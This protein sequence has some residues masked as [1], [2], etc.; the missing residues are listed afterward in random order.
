[1]ACVQLHSL[2][3]YHHRVFEQ[4]G[5]DELAWLTDFQPEN[6]FDGVGWEDSPACQDL[7][8]D[9]ECVGQYPSTGDSECL[10]EPEWCE[11][12]GDCLDCGQRAVTLF[13][14]R[15]PAALLHGAE[16]GPDTQERNHRVRERDQLE[17]HS[18]VKFMKHLTLTF[19]RQ[20][21]FFEKKKKEE[22]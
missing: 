9:W 8:I 11:R 12:G 17:W 20:I 15:S 22:K 16:V 10:F 3:V 18:H 5:G 6:F 13:W 1:M 7:W 19:L 2:D 21:L 14:D 4:C